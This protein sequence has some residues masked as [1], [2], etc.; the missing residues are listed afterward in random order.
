MFI[1]AGRNAVSSAIDSQTIEQSDNVTDHKAGRSALQSTRV[2]DRESLSYV[3]REQ[4]KQSS[5]R[6]DRMTHEDKTLSGR[7]ITHMEDH[8]NESFP[9]DSS[10]DVS[11]GV[12]REQIRSE[13]IFTEEASTSPRQNTIRSA[14]MENLSTSALTKNLD[15]PN[16]TTNLNNTSIMV[17][18]AML[19]PGASAEHRN[20]DE[21]IEN[22]QDPSNGSG[23]T[24]SHVMLVDS[25]L[26]EKTCQQPSSV[27]SNQEGYV[28]TSTETTHTSTNGNEK[29]M[30]PVTIANSVLSERPPDYYELSI[31]LPLERAS[32]VATASVQEQLQVEK[33]A[34]LV[35]EQASTHNDVSGSS[36]RNDSVEDRVV[37][38]STYHKSLLITSNSQSDETETVQRST[39]RDLRT[40]KKS[41]DSRAFDS[42]AMRDPFIDIQNAEQHLIGAQV[43]T[44]Q[45]SKHKS[46][47]GI[48]ASM[49]RKT[50]STSTCAGVSSS[51][52]V[53]V[54]N[55]DVQE[56]TQETHR[57]SRGDICD[58]SLRNI[59]VNSEILE[60]PN[61]YSDQS[62][63]I[64]AEQQT[65]LETVP[66][67]SKSPTLEFPPGALDTVRHNISEFLT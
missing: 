57:T 2:E 54:E 53:F 14:V 38:I 31:D 66:Q 25:V 62:V 27:A 58:A 50:E 51:S 47:E 36:R 17:A 26:H 29:I 11:A 10:L 22:T 40:E 30:T 64:R 15:M 48:G 9:T 32:S 56:S 43:S 7:R 23:D 37:D 4:V 67:S 6:S 33:E 12:D 1:S 61:I 41:H 65:G 49:S 59:T 18:D 35:A 28:S 52:S 34:T 20:H 44:G 60:A 55:Q 5:D 21:S 46:L 16:L 8:E 19:L 42:G 45:G 39:Q 63:S 3:Q 13:G 24:S